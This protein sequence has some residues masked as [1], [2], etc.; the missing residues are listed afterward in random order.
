MLNR[1]RGLLLALLLASTCFADI[2]RSKEPPPPPPPPPAGT[3]ATLDVRSAPSAGV[4]LQIPANL[5]QSVRAGVDDPPAQ[6][7]FRTIVAGVLLSIAL[8]VAGIWL[9]RRKQSRPA[10]TAVIVTAIALIGAGVT[11][12][13]MPGGGPRR[14][15]PPMP[16]PISQFDPGTLLNLRAALAGSPS[17]S[18]RVSVEI[19]PEGRNLTLILPAAATGR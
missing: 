8:S 9:V 12:A 1:F 3:P 11:L 2:P 19:V 5:L 14:P 18:G 4:T 16:L 13:D 17:L 15:R 7:T 10:Q 6:D